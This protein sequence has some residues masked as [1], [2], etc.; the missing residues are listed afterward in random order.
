MVVWALKPIA[1]Q[2]PPVPLS[3]AMLLANGVHFVLFLIMVLGVPRLWRMR[4][5]VMEYMPVVLYAFMTIGLILMFYGTDRYILP[6]LPWHAFLG[7]LV[8]RPTNGTPTGGAAGSGDVPLHP[9][10]FAS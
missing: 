4:A 2:V 3:I 10:A 8:M 5:L 1:S 6:L 9:Q 7:I